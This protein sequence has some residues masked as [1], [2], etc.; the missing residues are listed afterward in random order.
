MM[1]TH[2]VPADVLE[3]IAADLAYARQQCRRGCTDRAIDGIEAAQCKLDAIRGV[4]VGDVP[5]GYRDSDL[6][7]GQP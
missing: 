2:L 5:A 1:R 4:E 7:G 6:D 3:R